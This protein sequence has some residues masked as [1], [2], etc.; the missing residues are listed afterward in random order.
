MQFVNGFKALI[1]SKSSRLLKCRQND[2]EIPPKLLELMTLGIKDCKTQTQLSLKEVVEV[3]I[4]RFICIDSALK[5]R[6][7]RS[8]FWDS[9]KSML[10]MLCLYEVGTFYICIYI[11]QF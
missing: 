1:A 5:I 11:L 2:V 10:M 6:C 8:T 7:Q 3:T 9:K 4:P